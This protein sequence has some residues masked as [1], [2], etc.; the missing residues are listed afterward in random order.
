[1]FGKFNDSSV[2]DAVAEAR[3]FLE[4]NNLSV[5]LGNTTS[6][7]IKGERIDDQGVSPG[8]LLDLAIVVGGDGTMLSAARLLSKYGVPAIGIN[9]G[10]LGFLT[11][12]S[13]SELESSL[14]SILNGEYTI[15]ERTMLKCRIRKNGEKLLSSISLN[16]IVISKGNTGRLIE[17]EI[18]V[19][20]QFVSQPRSDGLII[21]TPTGST[22]YALSAGGPIVYPDL[23]VI[24]LSPICPHTLSNRPIILDEN[25]K[26]TISSLTLKEAPAILT[27]DGVLV[28]EL[29]G[30]ET[31]EITKARRK[32]KLVRIKGFNYFETLYSKLGWQS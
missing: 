29:D 7:E 27:M 14:T 13:L 4:K 18:K 11:D 1:L 25:D 23:P 15:E 22:A 26:I 30:S 3:N 8:K 17:F 20:G 9:L 24:S 28:H 10:R 16:D 12:I 21:S 31:I 32:L 6:A 19:N 5:F 2:A